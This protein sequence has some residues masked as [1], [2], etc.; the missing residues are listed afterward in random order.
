MKDLAFAADGIPDFRVLS[1]RLEKATGWRVVAVP[2]LVPDAVFFEH[3]ANRRFPAT[4]WIRAPE[5]LDYLQEPD[6]FH[7]IFGHVPLLMNPVFADFMAGYGRG[8]LKALDKGVLHNLARL[9]WYTVEFGLIRGRA[10]LEIFGAGILSSHS[11]S[12]FALNSRSPHR[13][14]FD[15]ARVMRTNYR[16]DD[17]QEV[18]FVIE[19]FEQLLALADQPFEPLYAAVARLPALQPGELLAGDV[20]LHRGAGGYHADAANPVGG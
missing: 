14:A 18:Y 15:L 2:G 10:G 20:V 8:G 5:N 1:E 11:E 13:L 12:D 17:F 9:Y 16:I 19:D 6:V 4:N 7:D 3:L